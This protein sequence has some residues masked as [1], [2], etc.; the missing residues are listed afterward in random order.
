MQHTCVVQ[1]CLLLVLCELAKYEQWHLN[2][3]GT[4]LQQAKKVAF[5][6][7]GIVLGVHDVSDGSSETPLDTL[8]AEL[9]KMGKSGSDIT[10]IVLSTSDGASAQ[11]KFNRLLEKESRKPQ[12]TIVE[13]KCAMHLGVNLRHAQVKAMEDI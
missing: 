9:Q 11:C 6:I 1:K 7:N 8:K 4:T 10:H 3:D 12:G 5:L 2:S 13:N